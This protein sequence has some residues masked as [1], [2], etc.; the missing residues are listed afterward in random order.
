MMMDAITP[1]TRNLALHRR[2][3]LLLI[4]VCALLATLGTQAGTLRLGAPVINGNQY[5]FPVVLQGNAEGVAALDFRL[6]YDPAVFTPVGAQSGRSALQA[7][8]QVSSNVSAPGEFIVV[9][10]GFNQNTVAPGEVVE[11]VLEKISNAADGNTVLRIAQPTLAT[12]VGV[13]I[14]SRGVGR[15][16]RFDSDAVA[17]NEDEDATDPLDDDT[18]TTLASRNSD[19][20]APGDTNSRQSSGPL[21]VTPSPYQTPRSTST[22]QTSPIATSAKGGTPNR[23][24][25]T[26]TKSES[27]G[28]SKIAAV[29]Q[30]TATAPTPSQNVD[31]V[32]KVT[33]ETGTTKEL[34]SDIA[35]GSLATKTAQTTVSKGVTD[36]H[37]KESSQRSE[38]GG[39]SGA[40]YAT[41]LL[42]AIGVPLGL[43]M[44]L[45][46]AGK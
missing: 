11:V 29:P 39:Q 37:P 9:L 3:T 38:R 16:V 33:P 13:E 8:K 26:Q 43:F 1:K 34:D 4:G 12:N 32:A 5:T 15:T 25:T 40:K 41:L 35:D 36:I 2:N 28:N 10:V 42:L 18:D 27:V 20:Q 46:I 30:D 44:L 22:K 6:A 14:D 7:Q 17:N 31:A 21:F 24:N 23:S 45:R 19:S